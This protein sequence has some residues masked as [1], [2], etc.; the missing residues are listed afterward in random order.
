MPPSPVVCSAP[1]MA[2]PLLSASTACPL[3]EPKLMA[4]TFTTDDGPER[5]GPPRGTAEHLGAR[6]R[7]G[8]VGVHRLVRRPGDRE[9][10]LLDDRVVPRVLEVVV[11]AEPEVG[12]LALGRRVH[13]APLVAAERPLLVV[14]GDDVLAQLG[15]DRLEEEAEVPDDREVAQDGVL[16]LHEVVDRQATTSPITITTTTASTTHQTHGRSL[17]P[18]PGPD[19][20]PAPGLAARRSDQGEHQPDLAPGGRWPSRPPGSAGS[21]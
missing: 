6:Q 21:R 7:S 15:T 19:G 9:G 5:L 10:H 3:S 8:R 12:V 17:R 2:Q 1:A 16:L 18:R 11:G 14:V 13:P 4:D 20:G